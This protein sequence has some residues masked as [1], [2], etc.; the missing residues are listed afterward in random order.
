MHRAEPGADASALL[1]RLGLGTLRRQ[2][3]P[4]TFAGRNRTWAGTTDLGRAVLVKKFNGTPAEAGPRLRR[5]VC[6]EQLVS[7]SPA[8]NLV[9]PRCLGW[10]EGAGLMAYELL[11]PAR[12]GAD[13]VLDGDFGDDLAHRAGLAI[14]ELHMLPAQLEY[15]AERPEIDR[16][17]PALPST[18]LLA[19]L[20]PG[21]FAASSAAE[22]RAWRLMQHD[23]PLTAAIGR[24]LAAQDPAWFRPAHCDLRIE[25]FFAAGGTLYLCDW[26]EFRLADPARDVGS[27]AGEWLHQAV[28]TMAGDDGEQAETWSDAEIG[29]R[30]ADNMRRLGSRI[31]A[32]WTGY[33][34][35]RPDLDDDPGLPVRAAAFA[36][37]HLFDRMLAIARHA[38]RLRAI[39]RAAAGIGRTMLLTPADAALTIG[40]GG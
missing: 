19:G 7:S 26:E 39:D 33:L 31:S 3:E 40:L 4:R 12:S 22:L 20:S 6:F 16:S 18:A 38:P 1:S 32:F 37:W 2:D 14:G 35:A 36:G 27:F 23:G 34:L 30:I 8:E 10:D 9:T 21:V 17:A 29:R 13:L 24:L 25:Q 15:P 28:M 5:S 11:D